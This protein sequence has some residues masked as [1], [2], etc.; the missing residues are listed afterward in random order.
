ME[1][2]K[3]SPIGEK[4]VHLEE[5][6]NSVPELN[7]YPADHWEKKYN[8][9]Q[10][11]GFNMLKFT[12]ILQGNPSLMRKDNQIIHERLEQWRTLQFGDMKL[13]YLL[14]EQPELLEIP[15][16]K[17]LLN[18]I[19][20]IRSLIGNSESSLHKLLVSSPLVLT[21]SPI[22]LNEMADFLKYKLKIQDK[23]EIYKSSA[24]SQDLKFLKTRYMFMKRLGIYVVKWKVKENEISK[25]PKLSCLVDTDDKKFATKICNVTLDEYEV[26]KELYEIELEKEQ[27]EREDEDED[28]NN[29]DDDRFDLKVIKSRRKKN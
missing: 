23:S 7:G 28:L 25:N 24:M 5:V 20:I 1:T 8:F 27:E 16:S 19:S 6:L 2:L 26:F 3:S 11:Q 12:T 13:T 4:L 22:Q 15:H 9:F 29:D 21:R 14:S 10:E 18:K 17:S